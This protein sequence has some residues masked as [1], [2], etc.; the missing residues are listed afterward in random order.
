MI[1]SCV[2]KNIPQVCY[3]V[4]FSLLHNFKEK[5]MCLTNIFPTNFQFNLN[6]LGD[7]NAGPFCWSINSCT[8]IKLFFFFFRREQ[9]LRAM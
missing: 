4:F 7:V 2:L 1:G 3:S 8:G 9:Q 5:K 6:F